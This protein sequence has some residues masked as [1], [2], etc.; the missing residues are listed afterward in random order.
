MW[1]QVFGDLAIRIEYDVMQRLDRSTI[2]TYG[3]A[4]WETRGQ[5]VTW[6]AKTVFNMK[7]RLDSVEFKIDL[8]DQIDNEVAQ[9]IDIVRLSVQ[10]LSEA[11]RFSTMTND[12]EWDE[13]R[14]RHLRDFGD[15]EIGLLHY[16]PRL[17]DLILSR[18]EK[19]E[20]L[21]RNWDNIIR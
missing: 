7:E 9:V 2:E 11:L 18:F 8:L 13:I 3:E 15:K 21:V 17:I 1:F 12:P 10:R 6:E 16:V 14:T 19:E 5:R 20:S 4:L